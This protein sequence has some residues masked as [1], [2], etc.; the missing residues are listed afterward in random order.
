MYSQ[1]I[2]RAHRSAFVLL[3][4]GSGSM[5]EEIRFRG[6][7]LPKATVVA[8]IANEL[9]YELTERARRSEGVR[10]YYDIAVLGYSGE[11]CV[12]SL[13]DA[14]ATEPTFTAIDRLAEQPV[15]MIRT[16]SEF[17]RPDGS[18][19]LRPID[20]PQWVCPEASGSTP[21]LEA[22]RTARDLIRTWCTDPANSHSFP[23]TIFNITDG[24]ATD[25]TDEEL[26]EVARQIRSTATAD[27]AALLINI[28]IASDEGGRTLFFP[29]EQET[30]HP[31]RHARLLH[32]A[33]SVMPACFEEM[34][35]SIKGAAAM[36][37]FRG[38]SFNA[39]A[40]E[41]IAMLNI[42]SISI[43]TE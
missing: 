39:S 26:L 3:I 27:G 18:I 15:E 28:H 6:E 37:P 20:T 40:T 7:L 30:P 29:G 21:M 16:V 25:G 22:L 32:E 31:N 35:R 14:Q 11:D 12:R 38:M 36:P 17:R 1:S 23:P 13:L 43:K 42:G 34:I 24:E 2:T 8:R 10:N 19:A 5:A 33:S 41:L 4:D 9:I